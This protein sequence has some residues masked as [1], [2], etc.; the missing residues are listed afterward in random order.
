VRLKTSPRRG[1][2][3][4][5]RSYADTLAYTFVSKDNIKTDVKTGVCGCS[6]GSVDLSCGLEAEFCGHTDLTVGNLPKTLYI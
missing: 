3:S 2:Q 5:G 1:T 4:F 6:Q